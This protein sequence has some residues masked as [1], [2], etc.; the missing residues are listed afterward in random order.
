MN[1]LQDL[2]TPSPFDAVFQDN[3]DPWSNT[4]ALMAYG[5]D[6]FIAGSGDGLTLQVYDFR[7]TRNYYHTTALPC[8]SQPPFPRPH[9]PFMQSLTTTT[10]TT[11]PPFKTRSHCDHVARLCCPWHS[12][13]QSLYYRPNA[14]YFLN[15]SL[16]SFR[17][18]SVWSLARSSDVAPSLYVGVSGGVLEASLEPTPPEYP[19]TTTTTFT[20]TVVDP[21]FGC[22]DWRAQA[23]PDSGYRAKPLVP[24]LMETGDGYSFKGNDRSILLPGLLRYQGPREGCERGGLARHHR[25]DIGYQQDYDFEFGVGGGGE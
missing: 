1:R 7:W 12:H 15:E 6:R 5:T 3:V 10:T 19:L 16:R 13:A 4:E 24:A 25:L 21:H 22:A 18:S 20:T 2:R 8:L 17:T 23:P 9:Q 14:K 11:T